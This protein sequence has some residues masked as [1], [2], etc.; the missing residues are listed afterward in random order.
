MEPAQDLCRIVLPRYPEVNLRTPCRRVFPK[1]LL[2]L[3][4]GTCKCV[5][6]GVHEPTP[7]KNPKMLRGIY[8][9]SFQFLNV[10]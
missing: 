10:S 7:P 4:L 5:G 6:I 9:V 8:R 1:I 2:Q 3:L